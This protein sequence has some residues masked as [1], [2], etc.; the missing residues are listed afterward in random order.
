MEVSQKLKPE[1]PYDPAILFLDIY[2]EENEICRLKRYQH[3]HV[4]CNNISGMGENG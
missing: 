1:L 2:P 4:H 3:P